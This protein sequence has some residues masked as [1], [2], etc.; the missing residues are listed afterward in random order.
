LSTTYIQYILTALIVAQ[1]GSVNAAETKAIDIKGVRIGMS[2]EEVTAQ[3]GKLDDFTI[4]GV[5]GK[6]SSAPVSLEYHDSKLDSLMFFFDSE[7]FSAVLS[8]V[9]MKFPSIK[10]S[11]STLSNAIGA[12]FEQ[13]DCEISDGRGLL[14]L[15]R[16]VDDIQTSVLSL[17]SRRRLNEELAKQ[18]QK[19]GDI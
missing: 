9:K 10:C 16:Y 13:I 7:D 15:S 6:Y 3:I 2:E 17:M 4:A 18:S 14:S 11:T 19:N 8:A 5:K 12:R 1:L